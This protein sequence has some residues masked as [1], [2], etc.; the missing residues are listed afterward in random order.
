MIGAEA[1]RKAAT[2]S[3]VVHQL[4]LTQT[5]RQTLLR[6]YFESTADGTEAV[7]PSAA[8]RAVARLM[9]AGNIRVVLTV[10]F[11]RLFEQALHEL[12]IEPTVVATE[13]DARGWHRYTCC[14]TASSISTATT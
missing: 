2:Y 11:D 9:Q 6:K 4:A 3:D 10:N 8:H 1:V 12:G 13:A 7:K 14:R 5:E